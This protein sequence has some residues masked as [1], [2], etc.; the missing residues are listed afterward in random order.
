MEKQY[1]DPDDNLYVIHT[2]SGAEMKTV[3]ACSIRVLSKDEHLY[4]PTV[5][6]I[7]RIHGVDRMV[8][9]KLF[10][11]YIFAETGRP[12]DLLVRLGREKGLTVFQHAT[13]LR[14][15]SYILP[16]RKE[17]AAWLRRLWDSGKTVRTSK[18][19][20]I[21]DRVVITEGPLVGLEGTIRKIDRH[22]KTAWIEMPFLGQERLVRV[23]LEITMK[24]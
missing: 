4:V 19:A 20:I 7:R 17:E 6:R 8:E 10:P 13:L 24:C 5:E 11:G 14:E 16:V 22:K 12:D 18:G 3:Q 15:D 21:G 9:E 2:E 23:G 1:S